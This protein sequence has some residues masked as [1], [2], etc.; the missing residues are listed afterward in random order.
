[1]TLET[2]LLSAL[3]AVTAA[4]CWAVQI[5]YA[6]LVKAEHKVDDLTTQVAQLQRENGAHEARIESYQ[7]CPRRSECPFSLTPIIP[8]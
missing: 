7:R 3:S 4:L 8:Q 2:A 6:R 1:M 5:L